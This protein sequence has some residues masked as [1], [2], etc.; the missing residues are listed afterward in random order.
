MKEQD[1]RSRPTLVAVAATFAIVLAGCGDDGSSEP[2]DEAAGATTTSEA[3]AGLAAEDCDAVIELGA[4]AAEGPEGPPSPEFLDS[5][6]GPIDTL[7]GSESA[8][9]AATG[10]ELQDVL[11]AARG[12]E[13]VEDAFFTA[14]GELGAPAH[15]DCGFEAVDV[16]AV[17]YA[18]EGIPESVP[19][20][21]VSF[22][23]TNDG[24]EEHEMVVFRRNEGETR[25]VEE[26][27]ALPE[28]E[29]EEAVSFTT[30]T[31]AP[32][33]GTGYTQSEL[34]P[35]GYIAVC[36]IPVGGAE[37]GPPHFT[38]GMSAEFE[39]G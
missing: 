13:D 38:E 32:P 7:A 30:A 22:A 14:F 35:G 4:A 15:E 11:D 39:V 31:F 2:G 37:D 21:P 24:T 5:L 28:A 10:A 33:G 1:M 29:V 36:F 16:T 8:E 34:E 18:Y 27:L 20:G 17:N 12:G 26:L 3:P 9:L 23:M 19:A 25:S 6:Q